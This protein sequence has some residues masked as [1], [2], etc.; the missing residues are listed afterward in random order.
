VVFVTCYQHKIQHPPELKPRTV[1]AFLN[2]NANTMLLKHL[3]AMARHFFLFIFAVGV[4]SLAK[5]LGVGANS[6]QYMFLW[7]DNAPIHG[8]SG[9]IHCGD[10]IQNDL[11]KVESVVI[12]PNPPEM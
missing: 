8:G 9:V 2:A 4:G 3:L 6:D 10:D 5:H 12:L 1:F 7:H 11:F